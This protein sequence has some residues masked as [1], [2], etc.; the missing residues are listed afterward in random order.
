MA[1]TVTDN[2]TT[3]YQDGLTNITGASVSETTFYAEATGCAAEAYNI[4][5][6]QIY[7]S[8]THPTYTTTGNELIYVWSAVVATQNGYK[9]ATA[10]NSSH[11]MW[12][13][14]SGGNDLIV[15]MAGN[16]RDVFKHA[17]GQVSFQCFMVDVDHLD[18]LNTD[19]DLAM[20]NGTWASFTEANISEVG[21][22][23]VTLSKALGGGNNCYMDIIRYGGRDDG[24]Q[25]TGGGVGTE[26]NFAEICVEDRG[27]ADGKAHGIIREYTAGAYGCQ[28][29]LRFGDAGTASTYFHDTDASLTFED[30][31]VDDDKF[32]IYVDANSTGTNEFELTNCSIASAG[33]GVLVDMSS[34]GINSL[35]LSG[36]SFTNLVNA[37]S[38]PTDTNGTTL[39]H[40]VTTCSFL[41]CGQIDPGGVVFTGNTISSTTDATG[42]LLLDADGTADWSDLTFISDGTGHAV[43]ATATGTYTWDG[44]TDT[45]YTG[46]RGTNLV[47]SSGSTDAMFY[48]NS[49]GLITLNV[50]GGGQAPSVRNGAGA[51]TQVNANVDVIVDG[52]KDNSEVRIYT[53][54]SN[55]ELAGI[56]DATAGTPDDRSFT[57]SLSAGSS[58]DY[59]IHNFQPGDEIYQTIRVEAFTWPSTDTTITVQQQLDRNAE[60]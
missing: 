3:L 32:A 41:G 9:E 46:T 26:G 21:S 51:T 8:G 48:N 19:G 44:H 57:A 13:G 50:S 2:R 56:E 18:T 38:F 31:P 39:D 37:I 17:D 1:V 23:Y 54:G 5:T 28:G 24:I 6:G 40:D 59:V 4:A 20:I 49:G 15:Y 27:T 52:L 14:D 16:D 34:S 35:Q 53:A 29:T 33:P 25:I 36:C 55:T 10:A 12:I 60:N 11:A 45:G 58:V 7:F 47:S 22:Y 30:R 42:G 43:Y